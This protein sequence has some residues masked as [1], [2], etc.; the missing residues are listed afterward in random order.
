MH[1]HASQ[2]CDWIQFMKFIDDHKNFITKFD[3]RLESQ[4]NF[5]PQKFEGIRYVSMTVLLE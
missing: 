1:V 4:N 2:S 3:I 5:L